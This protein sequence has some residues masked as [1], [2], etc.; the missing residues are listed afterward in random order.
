MGMKRNSFEAMCDNPNAKLMRL[1]YATCTLLSG[2]LTWWNSY[3]RT[4]GHDA[5]YEMTWKNSIRGNVTSSK[6]TILQEAIEIANTLMDQKIR[7]FAARQADNKTMEKKE[8][9]ETLP[10]CNKCKYHHIGR[11]TAKRGNCKRIGH[12][13]KD[14]R[15]LA[16]AKNQRAPMANQRALTCFECGK[17]R[18]YRSE[19]PELKN[20]N[21]G[22]Q[23]GS[24]EARGR[25]YAL[26]GGETNQDS[27]NIADDIDA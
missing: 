9:A 14:C 1:K 25:V 10:L 13:T 27:S 22:N 2:A 5:A 17:Q 15:S 26:G 21:R 23:A 20:Q 11:C 18:H 4:V 8:Y 16:A 6:P 12:Q 7:V 19:C 24:S 3:V